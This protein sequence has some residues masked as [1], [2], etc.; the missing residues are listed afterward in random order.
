VWRRH[1]FSWREEGRDGNDDV[2]S[3]ILDERA[4][5]CQEGRGKGGS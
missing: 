3:K 1:L 4:I 5:L 2:K